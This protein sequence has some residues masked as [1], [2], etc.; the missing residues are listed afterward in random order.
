MTQYFTTLASSR[1]I[2]LLAVSAVLQVKRQKEIDLDTRYAII[3]VPPVSL[4]QDHTAAV[5]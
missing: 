1:C 5:C 2:N 4:E 3:F